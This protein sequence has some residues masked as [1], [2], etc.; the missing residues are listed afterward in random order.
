MLAWT[1][2]AL[3]QLKKA[4]LS[5]RDLVTIYSLSSGLVLST[6][7]PR[8]WLAL[9]KIPVRHYRIDPEKSFAYYSS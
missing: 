2:H 9:T 6:L 3:R 5:D 8:T 7:H 1:N 4:G